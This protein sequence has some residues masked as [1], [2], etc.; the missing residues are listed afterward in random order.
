[1]DDLGGSNPQRLFGR[2]SNETGKP[3]SNV[4]TPSRGVSSMERGWFHSQFEVKNP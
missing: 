2:I 3:D 4:E 1:M